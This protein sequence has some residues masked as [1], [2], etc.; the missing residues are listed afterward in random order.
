MT[1]FRRLNSGLYPTAA[2]RSLMRSADPLLIA[3]RFARRF[4]AEP[5]N[6]RLKV[7]T[8]DLALSFTI[9]GIGQAIRQAVE[10]IA[11]ERPD[12]LVDP[13]WGDEKDEPHVSGIAKDFADADHSRVV[14]AL[15]DPGRRKRA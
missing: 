8:V 9:G 5:S 4:V 11:A 1:L 15:A 7:L 10:T 13:V 2:A 12:V 6:M 14:I 3:E